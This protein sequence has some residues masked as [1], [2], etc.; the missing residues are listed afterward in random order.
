MKNLL[1]ILSFSIFISCSK[2]NISINTTSKFVGNFQ[3][4]IHHHY[5]YHEIDYSVTP[6]ID[7]VIE[8]N[9]YYKTFGN[10]FKVSDNDSLII[11][12]G[13]DTVGYS[14]Y[15]ISVNNYRLFDNIKAFV[16]NDGNTFLYKAMLSSSKSYITKDSLEF[17]FQID[18]FWYV[19]GKR[20]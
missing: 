1:L 3:Y 6:H 11:K 7:R 8:V 9:K 20:I 4:D 10:I 16:S 14:D 19:K 2:E 12:W 5:T 13:N 18:G 17:A 15:D